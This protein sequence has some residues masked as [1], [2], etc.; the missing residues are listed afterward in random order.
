M[1]GRRRGIHTYDIPVDVDEV[2]EQHVSSRLASFRF[3]SFFSF[4]CRPGG[5]QTPKPSERDEENKR[6]R[7]QYGEVRR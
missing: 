4:F 1:D 2:V 7:K 3:F 6:W 5:D